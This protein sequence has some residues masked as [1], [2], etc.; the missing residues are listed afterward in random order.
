MSTLQISLAVVGV[1]LLGLIVAYNAWNTRRHAPKRAD[2]DEQARQGAEDAA[3]FEPALDGVDVTDLPP[4]M[5]QASTQ[6]LST[7]LHDPLLDAMPDKPEFDAPIA[8]PQPDK[9]VAPVAHG[10]GVE[11]PSPTQTAAAAPVHQPLPAERKLAL[12]GLIDAI[13]P[14]QMEQSVSGEAALQVQPTTRRA[15]SKPFRIEG[16]NEATRDWESVRAGQ[17]YNAFQAGVQLANR[18]G[19]L[20]EI[21]FSEFAAKA[22]TF[23]DA[24]NGA[25]ELP[26]MLHE[27]GRARELDQFASEHDAQLSFMLRARTAAWSPGY[28]RQHAGQLGFVMTNMPGRMMLPSPVPGNYPLLVLAFDA[29]AAQAA[30]LD[31]T[32]FHEV[33]LSLDVPQVPRTEQPFAKLREVAQALCEAMDGVLCDQNGQPLH[34]Q[35]LEPIAGDL[36]L[37]YDQLDQRELSAGSMLARRLFN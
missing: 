28:V 21:E 29:Q 30:D 12:D 33:M 18:T 34:P 27:V 31:R 6:P 2:R 23:A 37:L 9:A 10:A 7:P 11:E 16:F 20:N 15:G 5:R 14:I 22:Q 19:A 1:V 3:R 26:D 35:V 17:R 32:A 25:L 8:A 36:E 4:H 13:A 24:L